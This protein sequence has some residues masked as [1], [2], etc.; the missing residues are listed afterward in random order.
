MVGARITDKDFSN[1]GVMTALIVSG[2]GIN[3]MLVV[4]TPANGVT[5]DDLKAHGESEWASAEASRERRL[6][7][8]LVWEGQ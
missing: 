2:A 4:N 5:L 3:C 8:L 1:L 7:R 6:A